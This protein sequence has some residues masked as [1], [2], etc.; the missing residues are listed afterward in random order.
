M[1]TVSIKASAKTM[2]EPLTVNRL[3]KAVRTDKKI[4]SFFWP[5]LLKDKTINSGRK[6][7]I[8]LDKE[9]LEYLRALKKQIRERYNVFASY[10]MIVCCLL[11]LYSG[12]KDRVIMTLNVKGYKALTAEFKNNLKGIAEQ[13]KTVMPDVLLLQEFRTGENKIFLNILMKELGKYY[14]PVYPCSY[15]QREDYNSCICIMLVGKN[16]KKTKI[17]RLANE[18]QGYKLRYNLL[19]IDDYLIL[20]AWAPQIFSDNKERKELAEKM[21]KELLDTAAFYSRKK[22]RFYLAGDLNAFVGGELEDKILKLNCLMKDTKTLDSDNVPT[23]PVNILDYVFANKYA[24][25]KEMISTEVYDPS[26]KRLELS[27]H[28]A[29]LTTITEVGR[30]RVRDTKGQPQFAF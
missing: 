16:V 22:T 2:C 17:M 15:N 20:N 1:E 18:Q 4:E 24:D 9:N 7:S 30:Q 12:P 26:I 25:M 11:R 28:E 3:L 10:S 8:K 19:Q 23:G 6:V 29:L 5:R 14:K 27:D 13:V 21:W